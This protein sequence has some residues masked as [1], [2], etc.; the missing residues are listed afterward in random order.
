MTID[1]VGEWATTTV[2]IGKKNNIEVV[3]EINYPHSLGLLYS[4]FTYYL[5]FKVNSGEYKVMGLAPYGIPKYKNKI[6]ENILDLKED[7]SFYLDQSYFNYSTGLTMINK[8]FSNLFGQPI[9]NEDSKI[10]QF[11]MDIASSIQAVID[12]A[13]ICIVKIFIKITRLIIYV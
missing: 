2:S 10:S 13:V 9:R 8:K 3:K 4:A 7:G 12:E 5:G 11:H 1:G 6:L